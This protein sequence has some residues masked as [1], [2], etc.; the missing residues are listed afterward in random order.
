MAPVPIPR[1]CNPRRDDAALV[2]RDT[3]PL[4]RGAGTPA[5]RPYS[6]DINNRASEV[7][8][9]VW[10]LTRVLVSIEYDRRAWVHAPRARGTVP[11]QERRTMRSLLWKEWHEQSWKLAFGCVVLAALAVIGLRARVVAD[12]TM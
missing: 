6:A 2:F 7:L 3:V 8:A 11:Q 4:A 9:E 5:R 10:S 1:G 12:D